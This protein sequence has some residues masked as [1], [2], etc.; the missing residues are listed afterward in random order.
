MLPYVPLGLWV[1][2]CSRLSLPVAPLLR[3]YFGFS[4][5]LSC[6]SRL[7]RRSRALLPVALLLLWV[8]RRSRLLL[9]RS[10]LLL[11]AVGPLLLP[12]VVSSLLPV[13]GPGC[14]LR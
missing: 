5:I 11:P 13:V 9:R 14:I 6:G 12:W 7:L 10:R 2:R 1:L 3:F 4:V 8:L